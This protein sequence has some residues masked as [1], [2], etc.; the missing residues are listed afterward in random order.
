MV[1]KRPGLSLL[2]IFLSLL[3]AEAGHTDLLLLGP[4]PIFCLSLP[5]RV[6]Q[7]LPP[8]SVSG[9]T[10]GDTGPPACSVSRY[11]LGNLIQCPALMLFLTLPHR[12]VQGPCLH[13]LFPITTQ[14][15]PTHQN[16]FP[17]QS[18]RHRWRQTRFVHL[19]SVSQK[20]YSEKGAKGMHQVWWGLPIFR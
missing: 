17:L 4:S 13:A 19:P 3:V 6:T 8:C 18:P 5:H 11:H 12:V 20:H 1:Y 2:L 16:A 7:A 10:Q 9:H 14:R 15:W